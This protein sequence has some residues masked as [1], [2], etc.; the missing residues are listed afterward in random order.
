MACCP[1]ELCRLPVRDPFHDVP[2]TDSAASDSEQKITH[3]FFWPCSNH[4]VLMPLARWRPVIAHGEEDIQD[5][6]RVMLSSKSSC[7]G[8]GL[9]SLT[10]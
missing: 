7:R 4:G 6:R 8:G 2:V 1:G 3:E 9:R 5:H 10:A